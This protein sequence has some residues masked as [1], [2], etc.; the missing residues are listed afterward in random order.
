M[1]ASSPEKVAA[2]AID[3]GC[4]AAFLVPGPGGR[5]L[6]RSFLLP[7]PASAPASMTALPEAMEAD[8]G[9]PGGF[10][11]GSETDN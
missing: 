8:E 2:A 3:G 11:S 7:I 1:V 4:A 6:R 9:V 10:R 5:P